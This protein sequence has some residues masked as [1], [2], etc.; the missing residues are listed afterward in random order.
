MIPISVNRVS[1]FNPDELQIV[2]RFDQENLALIFFNCRRILY[3][4][5]LNFS[6][7]DRMKLLLAV[8]VLI[9]IKV[10][11][12]S[13]FG[14]F[15]SKRVSR[16]G[17]A[18]LRRQPLSRLGLRRENEDGEDLG[19]EDSIES[20]IDRKLNSRFAPQIFDKTKVKRMNKSNRPNDTPGGGG[21][22]NLNTWDVV[23]RA[24]FAGIFVAGIGAGITIDSAINTNPKVGTFEQSYE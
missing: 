21:N 20:R 9:C 13:A 14:G 10:A 15:Q 7:T 1:N 12:V 11:T 8:V 4:R 2:M 5:R 19:D 17:S 22:K 24:V 18:V 16:F 6:Q 23:N 3:T